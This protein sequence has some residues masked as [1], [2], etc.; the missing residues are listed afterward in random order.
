MRKLPY[1][2][3]TPFAFSFANNGK[4]ELQSTVTI[5][6]FRKGDFNLPFKFIKHIST[7]VIIGFV[8]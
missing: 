2:L 8:R 6:Q 5:W 1:Y 4:N 7:K 3:L